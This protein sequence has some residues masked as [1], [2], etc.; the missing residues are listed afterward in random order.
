MEPYLLSKA[1]GNPLV[2]LKHLKE[3]VMQNIRLMKGKLESDDPMS[4][5]EMRADLGY[6]DN[7]WASSFSSITWCPSLPAEGASLDWKP[8]ILSSTSSIGGTDWAGKG[9]WLKSRPSQSLTAWTS[10]L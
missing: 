1:L 4:F 3:K 5:V 8:V 7:A 10:W 2:L 9:S 6:L